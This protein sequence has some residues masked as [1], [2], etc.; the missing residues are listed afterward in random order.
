MSRIGENEEPSSGHIVSNNFMCLGETD[1]SQQEI[2]CCF[3]K[4]KQNFSLENQHVQDLTVVDAIV[5]MHLHT[6]TKN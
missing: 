1:M 3:K 6:Q 2:Q 4:G 5:C